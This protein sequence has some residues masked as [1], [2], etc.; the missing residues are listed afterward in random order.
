MCIAVENHK[1]VDVEALED[2]HVAGHAAHGLE[3]VFVPLDFPK[4]RHEAAHVIV[5][6][7]KKDGDFRLALEQL[8]RFDVALGV[9]CSFIPPSKVTMIAHLVIP[10]ESK[11]AETTDRGLLKGRFLCGRQDGLGVLL[12]QRLELGRDDAF[13]RSFTRSSMNL[14]SQSVPV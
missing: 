4:R 13:T 7:V 6:I 12:C 11:I 5:G 8:V 14:T 9:C 2:F 3:Q 1:R 10:V